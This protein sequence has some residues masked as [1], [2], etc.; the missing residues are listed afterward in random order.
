MI[1]R[2]LS[3]RVRRRRP[4]RHRAIGIGLAVGVAGLALAACSSSSPV[5]GHV[6]APRNVATTATPRPPRP[7]PAPTA[8]EQPGWTVVTQLPAGI[9]VDSHSSPQSDGDSVTVL[10]FHAGLVHYAL[11]AG[12]SDPPANDAALPADAQPAIGPANTPSCWQRSTV[13]SRW[14]LDAC[15]AV[16]AAWK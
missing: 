15:P 6:V 16:W 3:A 8:T 13:A 9:A 2:H 5:A 7:T 4:T 12:Y 14:A 1:R 10:R 11:H